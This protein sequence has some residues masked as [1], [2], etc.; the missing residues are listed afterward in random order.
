MRM[1]D[2]LSFCFLFFKIFEA[3]DKNVALLSTTNTLEL[4]KKKQK[5]DDTKEKRRSSTFQ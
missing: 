5:N 1:I 4:A 2:A 3:A